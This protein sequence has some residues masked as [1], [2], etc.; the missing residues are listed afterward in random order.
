MNANEKKLF[1]EELQ[2]QA[3]GTVRWKL[4]SKV[5]LKDS[6]GGVIG[7]LG[8]YDDI[9]ARKQA[10]SEL[11]LARFS[12]DHATSS[13]LW[14]SK[15][16]RIVDFNAAF[17]EMLQYTRDEL[18]TLRISDIDPMYT[19]DKW[20]LHWEELREKQVL[21]FFTKQRRKDGKE[22]DVEVRAHYLEFGGYEYNCAFINDITERKQAEERLYM[23]HRFQQAVLNN[24][25]SGVFW[26]DRQSKYLGANSLFLT[27]A[28]YK[29][30]YDL[31]GK[32]D[33]DCPWREQADILRA[34]DR[35]VMENNISKLYYVE[36]L[37]NAD[38]KIHYNEVSKV[39]L[40]NA[41]G[42]VMGVLGTFRDIT[43]QKEIELALQENEKLFKSVV[44]NAS[45]I[46]Y[47]IDQQGIFRLSEGLGLAALGL[48]PGEVIGKSVFEMYKDVPE[49]T[50]SIR[51]ALKGEVIENEISIHGLTFT[52]RY[53]PMHSN[54]GEIT[55]ILC[56]SFDITTRK[57]L[58]EALS[59]LN[60]ELAQ[61]VNELRESELKYRQI[62]HSNPMG[63]Y[64]YEVN[65]YGQLILVDT[66]RSADALTG[67][68]NDKLIG[69]AIEEAFPG[70]ERTEM[71]SHF[72]E[73][74]LHGTSWFNPDFQFSNGTINGV[75]EVYAFQAGRN[76]VAVMFLNIT[77]R[78]Q[79][80]A[81]IKLKN[82]ELIKANAELDR[83]VYSASHDLRAPIASLLGLIGVARAEKDMDNMGLLLDMQERSLNKLDN[84]IHDIVSY[85]RNNRVN[86]ETT[87]IDFKVMI[88][89]IFEQLYYMDEFNRIERRIVVPGDL[90]F[91]GDGKRI[92]VILNNLISNAIKY[93]DSERKNSFVEVSVDNSEKGVIICV[94]DNGEGIAKDY[95]PKIFDMFF[96]ATQRSTGSGIG[97]YIVNEIVHKMEGTIEVTSVKGEGSKFMVTLPNLLS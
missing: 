76:R 69:K 19:P 82:E 1:F 34:D 42:E 39:P 18:L 15:S 6:A 77:E 95:L 79:I 28:N 62:I 11:K 5:P 37:R 57:K 25:P 61:H 81:A 55:S 7:L 8:T 50:A 96:R 52:T 43:E 58:E 36:P 41:N 48:K 22:L 68:Q 17:C 44:Q 33:F 65:A 92:A 89:G 88:E 10:E 29:N 84:F 23:A 64:V 63:I 46:I 70:L 4:T 72:L 27:I 3:N 78:K 74:A 26:K 75:F 94:S 93:A 32:T 53:A 67:I 45:A 71:P 51:Q 47:I 86:V 83:F 21:K 73:A 24:I 66:N 20:P 30:E 90:K 49:I 59:A 60:E 54:T 91:W 97:L 13:I 16:A 14:I 85:S 56:V 2:P 9:T 80:E 38:G 31:I 40:L 87:A 35:E 12:I